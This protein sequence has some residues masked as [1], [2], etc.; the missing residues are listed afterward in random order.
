M[1]KSR[2]E[3]N[4]ARMQRII[5]I[6]QRRLISQ[7]WV[8]CSY[9]FNQDLHQSYLELSY[10]PLVTK[11]QRCQNGNFWIQL[12]NTGWRVSPQRCLPEQCHS[13]QRLFSRWSFLHSYKLLNSVDW[14]FELLLSIKRMHISLFPLCYLIPYI[15]SWL[16]SF[17]L[18]CRDKG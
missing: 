9:C 5:D 10:L 11:E 18:Y 1:K 16:C 15:I 17:N 8:I 13:F 2:P 3:F 12:Q 6:C 4:A 7:K 14:D